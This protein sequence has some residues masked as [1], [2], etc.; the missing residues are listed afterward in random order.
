[1]ANDKGT[2]TV[3]ESILQHMKTLPDH[4]KSAFMTII[5]GERERD[6][7]ANDKVP[8]HPHDKG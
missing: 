4:D 6:L 3:E 5:E 2:A 1:M 7:L 8:P